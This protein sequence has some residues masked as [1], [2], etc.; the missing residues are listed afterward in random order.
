MSG[1]YIKLA[2]FGAVVLAG[3]IT[4]GEMAANGFFFTR[5]K[6]RW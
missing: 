4:T 3:T 5:E 2:A 1:V 6:F